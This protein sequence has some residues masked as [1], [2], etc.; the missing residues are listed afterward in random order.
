[1]ALKRLFY[2]TLFLFS[3]ITTTHASTSLTIGFPTPSRPGDYL[4]ANLQNCIAP[5]ILN[6]S[7]AALQAQAFHIAPNSS[8]LTITL[9]DNTTEIA[10]SGNQLSFYNIVYVSNGVNKLLKSVELPPGTFT[11]ANLATLTTPPWNPGI[12]QGPP[13]PGFNWRYDWTPS[14]TYALYDTVRVGN[15]VYFSNTAQTSGA[16][17]DPSLW[18]LMLQG[19]TIN[20]Q[21]YGVPVNYTGGDYGP[22]ICAAAAENPGQSANLIIETPGNLVSSCDLTLFPGTSLEFRAPVTWTGTANI[23][24]PSYSAVSCVGNSR[25]LLST[26]TAG[27][28]LFTLSPGTVSNTFSNCSGDLNYGQLAYNA[29]NSIDLSFLHNN[30]HNGVIF[31]QQSASASA[32]TLRFRS[33]D[34][35]STLDAP[36]MGLIG[37][38]L[39]GATQDFVID[40]DSCTKTAHCHELYSIDGGTFPSYAAIAATGLKNGIITHTTCTNVFYACDWDSGADYVTFSSS[41]ANQCG[42]VCFDHEA[43]GHVFTT[44]NNCFSTGAGCYTLFFVST[45]SAITNN[46]CSGTAPCVALK[47]AQQVNLTNLQNTLV[48]GNFSDCG[49]SSTTCTFAQIDSNTG[50]TFVNNQILNGVFLSTGYSSGLNII[51]NSITFNVP[52]SVGLAIPVLRNG[53]KNVVAGNTIQSLISQTSTIS[54]ITA[55][56]IDFNFLNTYLIYNN[57]L[58]GFPIGIQVQNNGGNVPANFDVRDNKIDGGV[59]QKLTGTAAANLNCSNNFALG[60]TTVITCPN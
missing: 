25:L 42:D 60:G 7:I 15:N 3:L 4:Q 49:T 29:G 47:N 57:T 35:R 24:L 21:P 40:G 34:N 56:N 13:G 17:F 26:E 51:N 45:S 1:L 52:T 20:P 37:E 30:L 50:T 2:L 39:Y 48:S 59:I 58:L 6:T 23:T 36:S 10:C 19:G 14:T 46:R 41:T 22:A 33:L 27:S 16:S 54:A 28:H 8:S 55:V 44:G 53:A 11:I 31:Q 43:A 32:P 9:H 5:T 38:V 18:T 12:I